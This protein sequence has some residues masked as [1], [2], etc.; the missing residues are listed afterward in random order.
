MAKEVHPMMT[1]LPKAVLNQ[2]MLTVSGSPGTPVTDALSQLNSYMLSQQGVLDRQRARVKQLE[3]GVA[4][5]TKQLLTVQ[6]TLLKMN[7]R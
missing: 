4:S 7:C 2:W 5:V 1:E 6:E 3:E